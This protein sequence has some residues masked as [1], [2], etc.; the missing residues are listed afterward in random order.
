M[1]LPLTIMRATHIFRMDSA[2][3]GNLCI[4]HTSSGE[5]TETQQRQTLS[6]GGFRHWRA[7]INSQHFSS[8]IAPPAPQET[9]LG[10][11]SL[12]SGAAH[13]SQT[14][15]RASLAPG[16]TTRQTHISNEWESL[17]GNPVSQI[18]LSGSDA[19]FQLVDF[20]FGLFQMLCPLTSTAQQPAGFAGSF[21]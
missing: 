9:L 16:H 20:Y 18:H 5:T 4:C 14:L 13:L 12:C 2:S 19:N 6:Q 11:S 7:M 17:P 8:A 1:Q 3:L 10:C 15:P 21:C